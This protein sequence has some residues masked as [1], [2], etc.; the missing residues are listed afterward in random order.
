LKIEIRLLRTARVGG[1][2]MLPGVTLSLDEPEARA[3]IADGRA[4]A[5][6]DPHP[7]RPD[8][9]RGEPETRL[10]DGSGWETR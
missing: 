6:D 3:L 8:L 5:R 2:L 1:R 4:E 7:G 10:M 9:P